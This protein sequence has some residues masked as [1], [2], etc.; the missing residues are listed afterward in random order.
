[1][2]EKST[3]YSFYS[4]YF[5]PVKQLNIL[6]DSE[7]LPFHPEAIAQYFVFKKERDLLMLIVHN[8]PYFEIITSLSK[9][10]ILKFSSFLIKLN[11]KKV[12]ERGTI[13][14]IHITAYCL[15]Y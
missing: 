6:I 8:Y 2:N 9:L 7:E 4:R 3:P 15:K 12:A 5:Q 10:I 14:N 11:L 13:R 1:M